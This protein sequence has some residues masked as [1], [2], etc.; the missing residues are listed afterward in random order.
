MRQLEVFGSVATGEGFDPDRS[1]L[2]LLVDYEPG[3]C[4]TFGEHLDLRDALEALAG[5]PVDLVMQGAVENPYVQA[6]IERSRRSL[7]AA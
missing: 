4:P 3:H 2:D 6:S 5:H 1:D 7:Y